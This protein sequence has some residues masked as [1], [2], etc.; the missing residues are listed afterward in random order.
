M[1]NTYKKYR[2]KMARN[3][4]RGEMEIEEEPYT[5]ATPNID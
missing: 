5:L 3:I 1:N 2:L 4:A